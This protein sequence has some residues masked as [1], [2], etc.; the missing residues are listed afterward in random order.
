MAEKN[1][2]QNLGGDV[3]QP[4]HRFRLVLFSGPPDIVPWPGTETVR[5]TLSNDTVYNITQKK[6]HQSLTVSAPPD[7]KD[8]I[9][10]K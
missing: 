4:Q 6:K 9:T 7:G 10:I 1:D 2:L 3:G 8:I 5:L